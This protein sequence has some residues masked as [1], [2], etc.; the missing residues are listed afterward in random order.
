[1]SAFALFD[2]IRI[3]S[4][5]RLEEYKSRAGAT[6]AQYGGRYLVLGGSTELK[7]GEWKP[8][9]P[10]MIEFPSLERA[11]AWYN[12]EEY[13]PLK[14]LRFGAGEFNAVFIEGLAPA[15]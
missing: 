1:M 13:R 5:E 12:S 7:E 9:F 4:P 15:A 6:V 2:N 11:Q 3:D 8:T 10:V 14:E